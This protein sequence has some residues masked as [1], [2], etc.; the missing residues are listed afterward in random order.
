MPDHVAGFEAGNHR[1][2]RIAVGLTEGEV[3]G[4]IYAVEGCAPRSVN[5][6]N[7]A[8]RKLPALIESL[9]VALKSF[10]RLIQ[11][12]DLRLDLATAEIVNAGSAPTG[13][14]LVRLQPSDA[15][16]SFALAVLA[17]DVDRAT[18]KDSA[19]MEH[20]SNWHLRQT[21]R[22]PTLLSAYRS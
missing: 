16:R 14:L 9:N 19:H 5:F 15:L 2:R 11:L 1:Q 4:R 7:C 3:L 10:R 8:A 20:L 12:D 21:A 22:W 18:I 6:T 17:G 13:E